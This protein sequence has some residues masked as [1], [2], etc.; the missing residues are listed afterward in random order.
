MSRKDYD[1]KEY[2]MKKKTGW[3]NHLL[4][5]LIVTLFSS[6]LFSRCAT[7]QP[8]PEGGPR[9]TIPPRVVG[10]SPQ[11]NATN[12]YPKRIVI[13]FDE[14]IQLKEMQQEFF[15]SPFMKVKPTVSFKNKS[16]I[17][18]IDSPLDSATTYVLDL[19]SGVADNNEGN[20]MHGL[21][22][23][24]S[25]GDHIDSLFMS[26]FVSDAFTA[27]TTIGAYVF[28]YDALMDTVPAYDSLLFN[29]WSAEAVTKTRSDGGFLFP[30]LKPKDYKVYVMLDNNGNQIYDPGV[31]EVAFSDS[32]Y[33][34]ANM[35][36]FFM[37][38]DSV[39]QHV[40][41]DPQLYLRS[42]KED[43]E[44]TQNL[45]SSSRLSAQQIMLKFSSRNPKIRKF[46]LRD[47]DP[48]RI[49]LERPVDTGDS[50]IYW[51]N[52]PPEE[53]P[54]TIFADIV[55]ERHDSARVLYWHEQELR[56]VW[57]K[58]FTPKEKKTAEK[59][60]KK[61]S[62]KQ[63]KRL[64]AANKELTPEEITEKEALENILG[65]ELLAAADSLAQPDSVPPSKMKYAFVGDKSLTPEEKPVLSFELPVSSFDTTA[66]EFYRIV[67]PQA[68]R[69]TTGGRGR[70]RTLET[71]T[72]NIKVREEPV[73]L[74]FIQDSMLIRDYVLDAE[75]A[76]GVKY[77]LMIPPGAIQT[78]DGEK[79]DTISHQFQVAAER[80]MAS[81]ILNLSNADPRYEYILQVTGPDGKQI[82]KEVPHLTGGV[83]TINYV[84]TGKVG[85]RMIEDRN[86]NGKWDTG[87]L[88]QRKQPEMIS[89]FDSGDEK[90]IELK[91]N[92][93]FD[94]EI[95]LAKIFAPK[96]YSGPKKGPAAED[97]DKVSEKAEIDTP[98]EE[99]DEPEVR[100]DVRTSEAR[101]EGFELLDLKE[102]KKARKAAKKA[103]QI[104]RSEQKRSEKAERK[105]AKQA[106]KEARLSG[107]EEHAH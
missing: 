42:F 65:D 91:A 92:T 26:G 100:Q 51:L 70:N 11:F 22:Y 7:I 13:D 3:Y 12:I 69:P 2:Y 37:W 77:R 56:F 61:M 81:V 88:V 36:A 75:W 34:P 73:E 46:E 10:M 74:R 86:H 45:S 40:V 23:T 17:I 66:V 103:R 80:E 55:Y 78:I 67:V 63:Q 83:H 24:F 53:L 79:N 28:F 107:M 14:Y 9:D 48:E 58:P 97:E 60:P 71:D 76:D 93:E 30:H 4:T 47:I 31:D 29:A 99:V 32:L 57:R 43:P 20:Q 35:P 96:V 49:W 94:L 105:A 50:L 106:E 38:Y 1:T 27:D 5:V 33:N 39:R 87:D 72:T 62:R 104:E 21:R 8:T 6:G 54:D 85:L 90:T 52:V 102:D 19:G 25:T 44:R 41:A 95:D 82:L 68:E 18:D 84:P 16:V 101:V 59:K 98:Q 15:T 64:E 89:W